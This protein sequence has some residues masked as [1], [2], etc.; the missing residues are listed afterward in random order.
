MIKKILKSNTGIFIIAFIAASYIRFVWIT[1]RWKYVNYEAPENLIKQNKPFIVTF[2][3]GRLLMLAFCWYV[4]EKKHKKPFYMLISGHKDGRLI[5]KT[6]GFLRIKNIEGSTNRGGKEALV[7]IL[8][9]I[10]KGEVIGFTP[11]GPR[12]PGESISDGTIRTA[13]MAGVPI[14]PV[15]FS[16]SQHKILKTWDKFFIAFPFSKGVFCWGNPID[17]KNK[18]IPIEQHKK[19]LQQAMKNLNQNADKTCQGNV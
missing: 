11:D 7:K 8:K 13:Q 15:T 6:V 4:L 16:T 9:Y 10:K 5:S 19:N 14:L 2:F 18:K 3:H 12:G 17:V 1:S